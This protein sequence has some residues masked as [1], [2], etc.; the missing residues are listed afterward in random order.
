MSPLWG[1]CIVFLDRVPNMEMVLGN[2]S[3]EILFVSLYSIRRGPVV[4]SPPR[5]RGGSGA[6]G[7]LEIGSRSENVRIENVKKERT[8]FLIEQGTAAGA[9][10][11]SLQCPV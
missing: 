2:F 6:R 7:A 5:K 11:L 10:F 3:R 9:L 1:K 4:I 8:P